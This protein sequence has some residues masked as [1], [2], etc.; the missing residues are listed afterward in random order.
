MK[1][2]KLEIKTKKLDIK[3]LLIQYALF[4]LIICLWVFYGSQSKHFFT[5]K[6][7]RSLLM[8]A[9]P[10]LIY[11]TGMTYILILG[12]IDLSIGSVGG[13]AAACWILAMT[14]WNL[15][16]WA[17]FLI[18]LGVGLVCGIITGFL[19]VKLNINAFM[20]S[21][22]M[23]FALRGICYL[24]VGGEQIITP[25]V[26][27][28]FAKFKILTF[29]PLVAIALAIAIVMMLIYKFT[30]F[31]RQMQATGCNRAAAKMVGIKVDRIRYTAFI[32][33][34]ALAGIAGALQCT[35]LGILMPG[36][37]GEGSEFLA[38]TACVLGGTSLAGGLGNI[39]PGTLIG[40]IFY[41]S[42]ENGLGLLGANVYLYPV[43][44]G[45]VIYLAMVTD[46]LKRSIG[47]RY[48]KK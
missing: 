25:K 21:L 5:M 29:S 38:I 34:G 8:N 36:S 2:N 27:R 47:M 22:G 31:G 7:L 14:K 23:M 1:N 32:L 40:V 48:D 24:S 11:A 17:A 45:I 10:L 4:I 6:N 44:R 39:I 37:I 19:V 3:N 18:A 46:S 16:L 12:E 41:Y 20:A 26:V 43:V 28:T 13:L 9:S 35:N 33:S 42:I 15:P 30:A